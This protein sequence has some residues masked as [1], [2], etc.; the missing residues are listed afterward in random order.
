MKNYII[1][2]LLVILLIFPLIAPNINITYASN[3]D[4]GSEQWYR[5]KYQELLDEQNQKKED[6]EKLDKQKKEAIPKIQLV[7]SNT[8]TAFAGQRNNIEFE[9]KNTSDY[10]AKNIYIQAKVSSGDANVPFTIEFPNNS[11]SIASLNRQTKTKVKMSLDVNPLAKAQI[12]EISLKY[13][14]MNTFSVDIPSSVTDAISIKVEN[15]SNVPKVSL[16][17]FKLSSDN[18]VA[19]STIQLNASLQN[20]GKQP[21]NNVQV[22]VG[23]LSTEGLSV[24]NKTDSIYFETLEN[25]APQL[26]TFDI[27]ASSKIKKGNYPLEFKIS[28]KDDAGQ[29]ISAQIQ[30]FFINVDGSVNDE[31]TFLQIQNMT[32]PT[33]TYGVGQNFIIHLDVLNTG[34]TT[35]KN[36]KVT[37]EYGTEGA[38][39]PKS[40][41]VQLVDSLAPTLSQGFDFTFSATATAKSQNY[42][43]SFKLEYEDGSTDADGVP[44]VMTYTQYTGVN[45]SNPE[46]DKKEDDDK[47]LKSVPKIIISKYTCDPIMVKAGEEFDL[48][49]SFTNT[50]STKKVTNI[51]IF[52]TV[53]AES[54]TGNVFIPV[55]SSDTFYIE[56]IN[57]KGTIDKSVR[58]FAMPDAEPKTYNL[59]VNFDYEDETGALPVTTENIGISVKQPAKLE[60]SEIYIPSEGNVGEPIYI[61]F[62]LYN[63]GK[64]TLNNLRVKIV[65]DFD[66]QNSDSYFGNFESGNNEYYE[67]VI[68]PNASGKQTG[69]LI[70]S[71]DNP[72]GEHVEDITEIDLSVA[73]APV[74]E[75]AFS[76]DGKPIILGPDGIPINMDAP[77]KGIMDYVKSPIVWGIA[78]VIIVLIAIVV[79]IFIKRRKKQK[80]M[81]LDD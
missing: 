2:S 9:I 31:K 20:L 1:K 47:K 52:F 25:S 44:K 48:N 59:I 24:T 62:S 43:I 57:P 15:D 58:L 17:D 40:P 78:G 46:A 60:T 42:P 33:D 41:S 5:D 35:A 71:Y 8:F 76:P 4:N 53:S 67:G 64:V 81:D 19:G 51:K 3:F 30:K 80:G 32:V 39:V 75:Q 56:S 22:T 34:K 63:T 54:K 29:E 49:M 36:V 38:V 61:N 79:V 12:Y 28:Y 27:T 23:G 66:T 13:T 21:A 72:N 50:H 73:E 74:M 55:N 7:S 18:L 26:I 70:K 65:G 68:I 14:F 77:K 10:A 11:N 69:K 16:S 6:E 37:A 45:V